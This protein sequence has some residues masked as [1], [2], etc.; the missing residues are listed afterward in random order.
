VSNVTKALFIPVSFKHQP[1]PNMKQ[2]L[3]A[4]LLCFPLL[5][6]A[7]DLNLPLLP[8]EA[9]II[10]SIPVTE[11]VEVLLASKPGWSAR[12]A[13]DK[14]VSLGVPKDDIA[15]VTIQVKEKESFAFT[16]THDKAGHHR[17]W[18]V[19]AQQHAALVQGFAGAARHPDG[20]QWLS[21]QRPALR[22]V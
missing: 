8:D 13:A 14:L 12:G 19:A 16:V 5:G 20:P 11:G 4:F 17:Q 7:V 15:S 2:F 18:P 22:G 9:K 3:T 1:T 21:Q 6:N 10:Q